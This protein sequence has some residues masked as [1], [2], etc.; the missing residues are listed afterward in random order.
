M[1]QPYFHFITDHLVRLGEEG[2]LAQKAQCARCWIRTYQPAKTT[3]KVHYTCRQCKIKKHISD[4]TSVHI[5]EWYQKKGHANLFDCYEC[6]CPP[7]AMPGCGVRS[8]HPVVANSRVRKATFMAETR[9]RELDVDSIFSKVETQYFCHACKY[10]NCS[11][12]TSV[13]CEKTRE[14]DTKNRFKLWTCLP[15]RVTDICATCGHNCLDDDTHTAG[16]T[17][18]ESVAKLQL[19]VAR[20]Q[21]LPTRKEE[22]YIKEGTFIKKCRQKKQTMCALRKST[23]EAVPYWSWTGQRGRGPSNA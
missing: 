15:C 16:I 1:E 9:Q 13:H 4:F 21:R 6:Q 23:L 3:D 2:T 8:I 7:C 11:A 20:L 18:G 14:V 19:A 12:Q 10:P 17:F 22:P 5:I